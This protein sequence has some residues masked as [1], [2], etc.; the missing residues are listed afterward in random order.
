MYLGKMSKRFLPSNI[1]DVNLNTYIA[2]SFK[3]GF[4]ENYL[5][6]TCKASV[7]NTV[8]FARQARDKKHLF[9]IGPQVLFF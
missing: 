1:I 2:A 9:S 4:D 5:A 6:Y 8:H 3:T 7:N